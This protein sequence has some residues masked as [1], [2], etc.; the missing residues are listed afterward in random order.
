MRGWHYVGTCFAS[1]HLLYSIWTSTLLSTTAAGDE[2]CRSNKQ[3]PAESCNLWMDL[4]V[5]AG[6]LRMCSF[7]SS[8][9][10]VVLLHCLDS[11][12][13]RD[14]PDCSTC[15][16]TLLLC[17]L[18]PLL[19]LQYTSCSP[20]ITNVFHTWTGRII[21]ATLRSRSRSRVQRQ[22]FKRQVFVCER[23]KEL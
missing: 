7:S 18:L 3:I 8:Y 11:D 6:L 2:T 10:L 19:I 13:E 14:L 4:L 21:W 17:L 12:I 9:L 16:W 23:D 5:S 22:Q 1:L 15:R 20:G